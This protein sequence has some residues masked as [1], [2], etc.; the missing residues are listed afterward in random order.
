ML[1]SLPAARAKAETNMQVIAPA[2]R[3]T[4]GNTPDVRSLFL[5]DCLINFLFNS[6]CKTVVVFKMVFQK[7]NG[8]F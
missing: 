8:Q 1:K 5:H 4:I 7:T 3:R 6:I 2:S